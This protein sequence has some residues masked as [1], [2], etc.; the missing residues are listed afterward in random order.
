[1]KTFAILAFLLLLSPGVKASAESETVRHLKEQA[2]QERRSVETP[3]KDW[4][5]NREAQ[6]KKQDDES[7]ARKAK[8]RHR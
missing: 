5:K 7:R 6:I 8:E 3:P 1:M 4:Q 2:W